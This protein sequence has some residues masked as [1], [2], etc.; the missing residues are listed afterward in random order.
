MNWKKSVIYMMGLKS[1]N[2]DMCLICYLAFFFPSRKG[3]YWSIYLFFD[4]LQVHNPLSSILIFQKFWKHFVVLWP[5]LTWTDVR[6]FYNPIFFYPVTRDHLC[7]C[8]RNSHLFHYWMLRQ[9]PQYMLHAPYELPKM[10]RTPEL[11]DIYGYKGS[12]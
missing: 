10:Q 3:R 1:F 11:W 6:I 4:H 8:C 7:V 5:N 12:D 2:N 9:T